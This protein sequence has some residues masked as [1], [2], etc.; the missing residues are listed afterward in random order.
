MISLIIG[1]KGSGK[2]K[3]L[4]DEVNKALA[5]SNGHVVCVEKMMKL[6][7]EIKPQVRLINADEF[8]VSGY[9]MYYGFLAGLCSRDADITDIL[10]DGT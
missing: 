7:Y 8:L 6:T 4:I 5:A 10:C 9:D 3:H 1:N 2:T